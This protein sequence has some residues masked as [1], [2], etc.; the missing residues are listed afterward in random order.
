VIHHDLKPSRVMVG[1]GS[2]AKVADFGV[3]KV[4]EERDGSAS[5]LDPRYSSPEQARGENAGQ[6]ADQYAAGLIIYKMLSGKLPFV[7]KSPRGFWALHATAA[8]QP[9]G[10]LCPELPP[11]L[12]K[13]V[14]RSLSKDPADRFPKTEAFEKAVAAFIRRGPR[15]EAS[16]S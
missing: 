7:S 5:F 10:E 13:A 15:A 12:V 14:M 16:S 2:V 9:L 11:P 4:F 3:A 8:P 1:A 6:A